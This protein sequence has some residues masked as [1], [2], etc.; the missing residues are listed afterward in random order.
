[1]TEEQAVRT[2][3]LLKKISKV[4]LVLCVIHFI[5]DIFLWLGSFAY[6]PMVAIAYATMLQL[7]KEIHELVKIEN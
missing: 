7:G 3:K 2:L 6:T 5:R 1:M 4:I